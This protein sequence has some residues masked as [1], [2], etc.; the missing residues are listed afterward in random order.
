LLVPNDP[1]FGNQWGLANT[2]QIIQGNKGVANADI[3]VEPAWDQSQGAG[4]KVAVI[5]TGIDL[6]H[7]DLA[8]KVVAQKI[9]VTGSINDMFGHGTHVAGIIAADTNNGQGVA[10]VCPQC[11]LIIIKAMDDNGL[12]LT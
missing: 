5:D 10:G 3:H 12:G 11:L 4:V 1:L 7:P 8:S 9:I 6:S 2:G